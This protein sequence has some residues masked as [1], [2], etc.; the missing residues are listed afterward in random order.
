M[1]IGRRFSAT[2]E[3]E[4]FVANGRSIEEFEHFIMTEKLRATPIQVPDGGFSLGLSARE[5]G[6]YS[7]VKAIRELS[8]PGARLTGLELE[9]SRA[10]ERE[11]SSLSPDHQR[12][13]S[14][15]NSCFVP[16]DLR[17]AAPGYGGSLSQAGRRDMNVTI[18]PN[19]GRDWVPEE[20]IPS[21]IE[22]LRNALV[23]RTAGATVLT[24]PPG[25]YRD[26]EASWALDCLLAHRA[27]SVTPSDLL[28]NQIGLRP[29]RLCSQVVYSRQLMVQSALDVEALVRSDIAL[30]MAQKIDETAIFGDPTLD[31][32]S[33]RGIFGFI[34]LPPDAIDP[35]D[36]VQV[37]VFQP[38][39]MTLYEAYIDFVVALERQ[40]LPQRGAAWIINPLSWG[41]ALA[42]PKFV[43]TGFPVV[44]PGT[45]HSVVG[46]P[47]LRTNQIPSAGA[48]A[49]RIVFGDW[50]QLLIG[51][52]AGVELIVDPFSQAGRAQIVVTVNQFADLNLRYRR[53]FVVSRNADAVVTTSEGVLAP[54]IAPPKNSR[55]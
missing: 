20:F 52:W 32:N 1:E 29:R 27:G 17:M 14:S 6:S 9:C 37:R 39:P 13:R 21:L 10:I 15:G 19:V 18:A 41:K 23:V 45:P 31:A 42:T 53:A 26:P 50:A 3:A 5:R 54:E 25:K 12:Q 30:T 48:F 43:N 44:D 47:Y 34:E 11:M 38:A 4:D 8:E 55:E 33:P 7:L 49:S 16:L 46:Y 2:P 40:N 28:T 51:Q 35:T 36:S 24:G 22:Y